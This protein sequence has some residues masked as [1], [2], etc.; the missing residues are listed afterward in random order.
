MANVKQ[1]ANNYIH[2]A[3][4]IQRWPNKN[5]FDFSEYIIVA[6]VH[7]IRIEQFHFFS[8]MHEPL[9]K[10]MKSKKKRAVYRQA[11]PPMLG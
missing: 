8:L 1:T 10:T 11:V 7:L 6:G 5:N 3:N 9:N 2:A 4:N